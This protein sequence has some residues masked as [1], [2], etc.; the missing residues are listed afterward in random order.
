V[1]FVDPRP[2]VEGPQKSLPSRG[3]INKC[4]VLYY[5]SRNNSPVIG[6]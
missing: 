5:I 6:V 1:C 3:L 4:F 2:A